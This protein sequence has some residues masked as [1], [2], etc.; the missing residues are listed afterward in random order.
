MLHLKQHKAKLR[1]DVGFVSLITK[2]PTSAL[3]DAARR[4]R[5]N[6]GYDLEYLADFVDLDKFKPYIGRSNVEAVD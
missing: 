3:A 4:F 1:G 2:I 6:Q 5:R